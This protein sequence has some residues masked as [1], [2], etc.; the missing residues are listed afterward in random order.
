MLDIFGNMH[1]QLCVTP[2]GQ[3]Y[4]PDYFGQQPSRSIP[5]IYSYLPLVQYVISLFWK[6]QT[7]CYLWFFCGIVG[8]QTEAA[9]RKK[10]LL[11]DNRIV[12]ICPWFVQTAGTVML[13]PTSF[14]SCISRFRLWKNF[15]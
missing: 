14:I 5:F 6:L 10:E 8:V 7:V 11:K 1:L 12:Q 3:F 9:K 13:Y 2:L 4:S 15:D